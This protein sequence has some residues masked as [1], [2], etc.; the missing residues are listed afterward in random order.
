ML[1]SGVLLLADG[2]LNF[3]GLDWR[4][5]ALV[6]PSLLLK[7]T[8]PSSVSSPFM[9]GS[10]LFLSPS[11]FQAVYSL[12]VTRMPLLFFARN[13]RFERRCAFLV[14]C[15]LVSRLPPCHLQAGGS[16]RCPQGEGARFAKAGGE[17]AQGIPAPKHGDSV[18]IAIAAHMVS[19]SFF[20]FGIQ[21]GSLS[22]NISTRRRHGA[23]I[24][25][26]EVD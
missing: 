15:I 16:S 18:N 8:L 14:L 21:V 17:R 1:S 6:Y 19:F 10:H 2:C 11:T 3:L 4:G 5:A 22:R 24:Y 23:F 26:C 13:K 20:S 9:S 12:H 7:C 25:F